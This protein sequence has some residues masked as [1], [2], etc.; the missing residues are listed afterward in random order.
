MIYFYYY[1]FDI[2]Q[3]ILHDAQYTHLNINF[4]GEG[5]YESSVLLSFITHLIRKEMIHQFLFLFFKIQ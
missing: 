1:I 2:S 3:Y 5:E 4:K